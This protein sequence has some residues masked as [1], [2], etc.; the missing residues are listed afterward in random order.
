MLY[1]ATYSDHL[2]EIKKN[3]L[4]LKNETRSINNRNTGAAVF[5][6]DNPDDIANH[7]NIIIQID[8]GKMKQ[9][10]YTPDVSKET[11]IQAAETR[12]ALANKLGLEMDFIS[13]YNS[14][15]LYT[16][17]VIFYG[18]IPPK[19]LGLYKE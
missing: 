8:V 7:G 15:G 13:S 1:H 11:P 10:G 5:T 18:P 16:S 14:E 9:D 12:E 6:C 2:E 3:G 17:T 4:Q 19:Y